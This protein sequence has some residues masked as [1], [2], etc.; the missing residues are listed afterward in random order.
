MLD[1]CQYIQ[2]RC[3]DDGEERCWAEWSYEGEDYEG[4]CDEGDAWVEC[5]DYDHS[6]DECKFAEC[7]DHGDCW[8]EVCNE[9]SHLPCAE[10]TCTV[11][12]YD[13][14]MD[15]WDSHKCKPEEEDFHPFHWFRGH[16]EEVFKDLFNSTCPHGHCFENFTDEYIPWFD[17]ND[18]AID[19][20]LADDDAVD[21]AHEVI[22]S[23]ED[24][25]EDL[26]WDIELDPLHGFI[27]QD[28]HEEMKDAVDSWFTAWAQG[29]MNSGPMRKGK[30]G[31]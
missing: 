8:E 9:D 28:D 1:S 25:L 23:T 10:Y 16:F 30:R 31:D 20:F 3:E 5:L 7:D 4:T 14:E 17:E 24:A 2:C 27:E 6:M 11:W 12:L 15:Y 22:E 13:E 21:A 29:W 18:E 26:G 19:E